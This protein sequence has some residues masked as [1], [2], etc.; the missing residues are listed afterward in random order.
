MGW[1][2]RK[3]GFGWNQRRR[4]S[5]PA[6]QTTLNIHTRLDLQTKHKSIWIKTAY[7]TKAIQTA[8]GKWHFTM[9]D[10]SLQSLIFMFQKKAKWYEVTKSDWQNQII[11]E[12]NI[13]GIFGLMTFHCGRSYSAWCNKHTLPFYSLWLVRFKKKKKIER[14]L[15]CSARLCL[16]DG[17]S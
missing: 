4:G 6:A 12:E 15:L 11:F 9:C 8:E 17:K 5:R 7:G 16:F 14:N 13:F 10:A 1:R 3:D 2:W